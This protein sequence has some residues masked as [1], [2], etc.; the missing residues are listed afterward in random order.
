MRLT[1]LLE[2]QHNERVPAREPVRAIIWP[3][4]QWLCFSSARL[5]APAKPATTGD[6]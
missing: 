5:E 1:G 6:V 2:A 4:I 3:A